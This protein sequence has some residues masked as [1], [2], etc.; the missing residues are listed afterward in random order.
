MQ[1]TTEPS[2]VT[3]L[4]RGL[5]RRCPRCGKGALF[6]RWTTLFPHCGNC[7]YR[8]EK[9]SGDTWAFWVIGDR[10]FVVIPMALLFFGFTPDDWSIRFVFFAAVGVPL[11][12]TMPHRLGVCIALEFLARRRLGRPG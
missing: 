11:V 4:V 5:N 6:V 7:E 8:Y 12:L 3:A 2:A 10:I 9:D 1:G